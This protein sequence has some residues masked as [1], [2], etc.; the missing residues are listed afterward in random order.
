MADRDLI[1]D[2]D[3]RSLRSLGRDDGR[4]GRSISSLAGILIQT[5]IS[6]SKSVLNPDPGGDPDFDFQSPQAGSISSFFFFLFR[7]QAFF[8]FLDSG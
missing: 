5:V 2:P 8:D 1:L 7:F 4:G 3:S 6:V